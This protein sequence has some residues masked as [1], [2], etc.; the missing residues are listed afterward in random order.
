MAHILSVR[1][2]D[3]TDWN[4]AARA[5]LAGATMLLRRTTPLIPRTDYILLTYSA[6]T[7]PAAV[8][9]SR[10]I[11]YFFTRNLALATA[12]QIRVYQSRNTAQSHDNPDDSDGRASCGPVSH[13]ET[14]CH[15]TVC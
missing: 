5:C 3:C 10:N 13:I 7:A 8:G 2:T 15:I 11:D 4:L 1:L 6:I 14:D 12:T 9:R